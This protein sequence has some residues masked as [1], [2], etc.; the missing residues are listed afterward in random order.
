M[1]NKLKRYLD[2][3]IDHMVRGTEIDYENEL[4]KLP[5]PQKLDSS[6]TSTNFYT[7]HYTLLFVLSH[8]LPESSFYNSFNNYCVNT[9]GL[10][11][12]EVRY[13]LDGYGKIIKDKI[14]NGE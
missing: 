2:K 5:F 14:N 4:V 12:N 11:G 9:F 3:V 7:T 1:E 10:T 13:V 6:S 8:F